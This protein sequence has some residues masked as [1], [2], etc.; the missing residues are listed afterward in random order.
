ME[1][2]ELQCEE[3]D[4]TDLIKKSSLFTVDKEVKDQKL[5]DFPVS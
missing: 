5:V 3:K 2:S 4:F 1:T